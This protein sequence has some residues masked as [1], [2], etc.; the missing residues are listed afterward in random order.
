[1]TSPL[2][3][4]ATLKVKRDGMP[5]LMRAMSKVVPIMEGYG[6]KLVGAWATLTG[7]MHTVIDLWEIKD[8]NDYP[9]VLQK[10]QTRPDYHTMGDEL[11]EC[12]ISETMEIMTPISYDQG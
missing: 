10:M 8:A 11:A 2:Y 5:Q 7:E 12:L 1:M 6:W 3:L 9:N 4:K